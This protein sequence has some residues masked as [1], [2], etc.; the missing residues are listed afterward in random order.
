MRFNKQILASPQ[1]PPVPQKIPV[2]SRWFGSWE[3]AI[4]RRARATEDLNNQYD[5]A[6]DSWSRTAHH[7]Q[8]EA[9][10]RNPLLASG[11]ATTVSQAGSGARI[12]DCGV[13]SGS[14][15]I[16]LNSIVPDHAAYHGIDTS[17]G[18][19]VA[20]DAEMHRAGMSAQLEQA[21]ILSIPHADQSFD[22][23]MAA[24]VLE[25][26][27]EPQLALTEMI[28]VLKPGGVLFI[29]M[30]RRSIFGTFI[31]LRWRTWAVSEQQGVTWL[32]AG[33]LENIGFQPVNLGACAGRASTAFWAHKPV[34]ASESSQSGYATSQKERLP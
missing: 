8:L 14:L 13:G 12:L 17:S 30:T 1:A 16:A 15:S 6:S 28:R 19:L 3:V 7:F 18:M 5:V 31:Q 10:Y 29:C 21:N 9:G 2:T 4:N 22:V 20:A 34:E 27:P 23:V 11:A 26:L 32:R 24:H 25:H 33:H